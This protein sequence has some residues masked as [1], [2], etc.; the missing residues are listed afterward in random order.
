FYN[1]AVG[2][3][4]YNDGDPLGGNYRLDDETYRL[5][6]RS[7]ILKNRTASTPEELISFLTSLFGRNIPIFLREDG[8]ANMTIFFGRE[9]SRLEQNLLNFISYELGYPS[10]L[11]PMTIG[12]GTKYGYFK[13]DNFFGFQGVPGAKGF[14][15]KDQIKGW[16]ENWDYDWGGTPNG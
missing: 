13:G 8:N 6:I 1:P 15:D 14:G 9:L 3:P 7:K 10:K 12:V 4:F 5:F 11:I 16:G 2:A